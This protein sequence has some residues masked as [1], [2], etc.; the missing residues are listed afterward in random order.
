MPVDELSSAVR[1]SSL[2]ALFWL[3][4][5]GEP[6]AAGVVAVML[7]GRPAVAFTY[8]QEE[9]ARSA[10]GSSVLAIAFTERRSTGRSFRPLVAVGRPRLVEDPGGVVFTEHLLDDEL[11]RYPPS[12]GFA[13][14]P[15]LRREH[16]WYLPRLIVCLD[17]TSVQELPDRASPDDGLLA[18]APASDRIEVRVVDVS[19][20][21]SGPTV[22]PTVHGPVVPPGPAALLGQDASFPDLEQ[23]STWCFHGSWDGD[24]MTVTRAP[25]QVGLE[26]PRTLRQRLRAQRD[27]ARRCR[28]AIPR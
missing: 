23:W 20:P 7:D 14:S 12:R 18:V 17:V 15:L 27:L 26:P 28:A 21:A 1:S 9:R 16:W 2:A 19:S 13:D 22:V 6:A 10:A 8:A 5:N 25:E 4:P 3:T 11:R 24:L